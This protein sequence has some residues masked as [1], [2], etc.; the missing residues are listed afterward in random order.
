MEDDP[1]NFCQAMKSF[2]SQKWIDAMNEEIKSMKDNDVSDL[3]P[4]AE[5][6]KPIGCKQIFKTKRDSKGNVERCK[7]RLVAND[8][9]QKEGI[10]YKVT[11]SLVSLKDSFRIKMAL[12]VYFD[13]E[14]LLQSI[15][16]R[17]HIQHKW[18]IVEFLVQYCWI[19]NPILGL[20]VNNYVL[21][22]LIYLIGYGHLRCKDN[23][24]KLSR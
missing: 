8:F 21:Q 17:L 14:L 7:V 11:F 24:K 1:I 6:A 18:E 22:T 10:D 2:N 23:R 5:G 16:I 9:T 19:L 13:L 4:L 3:V 20:Y 15:I 12:V